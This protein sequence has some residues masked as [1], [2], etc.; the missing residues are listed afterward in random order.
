MQVLRVPNP[1]TNGHFIVMENVNF[2]YV[3]PIN[4]FAD[5]MIQ[6]NM[7]LERSLLLAR[8]PPF[9]L[10]LLDHWLRKRA[11]AE[12]EEEYQEI[13]AIHVHDN[14][15]KLLESTS[16]REQVKLMRDISLQSYELL[17]FIFRAWEKYGFAYSQYGATHNPNGLS[18][19]KFPTVFHKEFKAKL[20]KLLWF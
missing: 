16:K 8:K 11:Q 6:M 7:E 15:A 18:G 13:K 10:F 2:E 1:K 3:N 5:T 12:W 14:L 9:P 17:A 19:A 20:F 4:H